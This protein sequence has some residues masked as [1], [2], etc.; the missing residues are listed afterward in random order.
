MHLR[1]DTVLIHVN[2]PGHDTYPEILRWLDFLYRPG[3][4]FPDTLN[5]LYNMRTL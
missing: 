2:Y 3:K 1:T 5:M 4:L